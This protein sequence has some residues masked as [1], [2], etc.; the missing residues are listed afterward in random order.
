MVTFGSNKEKDGS[1]MKAVIKAS[2]YRFLRLS[3]LLYAIPADF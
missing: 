1:G 2:K 3:I